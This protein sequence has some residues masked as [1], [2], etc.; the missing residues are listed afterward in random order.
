MP[1]AVHCA[2][3]RLTLEAGTDGRFELSVACGPE[4]ASGQ[5]ELIVPDELRA[6]IDGAAATTPLRYELPP[7]GFAT[8]DVTV[9]AAAGTAAGRYFVAARI[10]DAFGQQFEDT[11]LVTVGEPGGPDASQPP[12][13]LFVRL[14]TDVQALAA[15]ADLEMLT[16]AVRLAPGQRGELTVRVASQL[17]SELRGEV[18]L[19][20]PIGTWQATAPWT[21]A[22]TVAPGGAETVGFGVTIPATAEP[23][24]QSWLLVKLMYFGRVRYSQAIPLTVTD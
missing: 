16:P 14:Q 20:S 17:R 6:E 4:P 15:E 11:A 3:T 2:P 9:R 22:V 13:E 24:W 12:E 23:G 21:Q 1:V 8:W 5:V 19:I 10:R 7:G 18:Q